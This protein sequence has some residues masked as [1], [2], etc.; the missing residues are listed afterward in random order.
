MKDIYSKQLYLYGK[1]KVVGKVVD[2]VRLKLYLLD[3]GVSIEIPFDKKRL[4]RGVE[5]FFG[6]TQAS[7]IKVFEKSAV[8]EDCEKCSSKAY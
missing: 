8:E 7:V 3:S 5:G 6:K 4:D 1:A 2:D